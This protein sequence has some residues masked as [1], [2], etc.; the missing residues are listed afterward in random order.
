M[1]KSANVDIIGFMYSLHQM[2]NVD[3]NNAD[4]VRTARRNIFK[5]VHAGVKG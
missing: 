5:T 4:A 3:T 1:L 2:T